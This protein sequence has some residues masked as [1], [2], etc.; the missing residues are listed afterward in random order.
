GRGPVPAGGGPGPE[1]LTPRGR[2]RQGW[3]G[4]RGWLDVAG[5]QQQGRG[6]RPQRV[7]DAAGRVG[8]A[9]GPPR[10]VWGGHG[11]PSSR[12]AAGSAYMASSAAISARRSRSG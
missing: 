12:T 10:V 2:V 4:C 11:A 1:L 3:T 6:G 5:T 7:E 8:E 9:C